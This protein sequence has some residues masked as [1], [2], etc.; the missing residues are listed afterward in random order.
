ME[1]AVSKNAKS[2][3]RYLAGSNFPWPT[4]KGGLMGADLSRVD[5]RKSNFRGAVLI[6]AKL[7]MGLLQ[8]GEFCERQA[9]GAD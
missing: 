6:G 9:H 1:A 2:D 3:Q 7:E 5:A 8:R 4:A